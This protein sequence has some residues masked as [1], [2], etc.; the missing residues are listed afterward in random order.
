MIPVAERTYTV[1]CHTNNINGK[2]YIGITAVRPEYRW[3]HGKGYKHQ[4]FNKAVEKYGWENFTH[5]ILFEGLTREEAELQE[6]T[7]IRQYNTQDARYGYNVSCGGHLSGR[8]YATEEEALEAKRNTWNKSRIRNRDSRL[9]QA[10]NW[11]ANNKDKVNAYKREYYHRTKKLK[12]RYGH[13]VTDDTKEKIS[14]R[15]SRPVAAILNGEVVKVYSSF[16][17]AGKDLNICHSNICRSIK[18]GMKCGGYNWMRLG[19][20]KKRHG[21]D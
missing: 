7:L 14:K 5:E 18:T 3:N 8:R 1:Y 9:E 20:A 15:V 16:K 11:R 4:V 10:R 2:K 12:G 6:L 13:I 17:E 21:N 19:E